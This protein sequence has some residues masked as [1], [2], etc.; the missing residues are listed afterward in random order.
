MLITAATLSLQ[1]ALTKFFSFRLWYHYAFMIISITMLGLSA[2]SVV[3]AL[4][5]QRWASVS[6][7]RLLHLGAL[8]FGGCTLLSLG[9]LSA[10][11]ER[12]VPSSDGAAMLVAVAVCWLLLFPAFFFSGFVVSSAIQRFRTEIPRIYA[13]DL[14]GAGLGCLM[15][16]AGLSNLFPE[17]CIAAA[18]GLG[19][20]GA[21]VLG[22]PRRTAPAI[23][24]ITLSAA[25][26]IVAPSFWGPAVTPTK[27]LAGDLARGARIVASAPGMT[28]RVDVLDGAL[29]GFAWGMSPRYEGEFPPQLTIRIDGDAMTSITRQATDTDDWGFTDYMP[30]SLPFVIGTPGSVLIIGPGGGMDVTNAVRRG[31]KRVVGVEIN[32]EIVDLLTG[33]FLEF[34][35][36]IYRHPNVEIVH[37]DGRTFVQR[38]PERFDVIQLTL[39]DTFAAIASGS[40][41]LAEDFLYTT[42][43]FEAYVEHLQPHGI[44]ALDRTRNE[45]ISL[46][47]LV[48]QATRK[49]GLNL[50]DHVLIARGD[51]V[52]SLAF[53]FK[54]TA[55]DRTEIAK[56]LEFVERTGMELVYAPGHPDRSAPD[57]SAFLNGVTSAGP[58]ETAE[59]DDA[60][61]Y[62]RHSKWSQL[63]GT[64]TSGRGNLLAILVVSLVF[65]TAFIV[66]PLMRSGPALTAGAS[67]WLLFFS[68]IGL[69]YVIVEIALLQ[70]FTLLLGHPTRSLTITLFAL[71]LFSGV[72]A[73][74]SGRLDSGQRSGWTLVPPLG[75]AVVTA[76]YAIWLPEALLELIGWPLAIRVLLTILVIAPLALLMGMSLPLGLGLLGRRHPSL[77]IWAW[78]INGFCSVLGSVL[79]IVA[80]H[81]MG[82]QLTL[83]TGACLYLGAVAAMWR[84]AA[85][86]AST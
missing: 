85:R 16:V 59:T 21:A 74:L 78:G 53:L 5:E 79:A 33:P 45:S 46:L 86:G 27:G 22:V 26:A 9:L 38:S 23:L 80:A 4:F 6:T 8:L 77:V 10:W 47:S 30:G 60:P 32:K 51:R 69:G 65:G 82:Y 12:L 81:A 14:G 67:G 73:L 68:M 18:A 75:A 2:A 25:A 50:A 76:A 29:A 40:L 71:L 61:F 7:R 66:L 58:N 43:A 19:F 70:H 13:F 36:G 63:L 62:F 56:G 35:G 3:I 64:Y 24:G 48:R 57:V 44:L 72:G 37:S 41:A 28:G 84:A 17:Q 39:V 31:A 42:E 83:L 49:Y 54:R 20:V 11:A 34:S 15:A 1:I 52:H 55:F